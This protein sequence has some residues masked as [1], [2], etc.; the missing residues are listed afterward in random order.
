MSWNRS[1]EEFFDIFGK[2]AIQHYEQ[3]KK[4]ADQRADSVRMFLSNGYDYEDL[5]L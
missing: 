1:M 5:R 3:V 4:K 2:L